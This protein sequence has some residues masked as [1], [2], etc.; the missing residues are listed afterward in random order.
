M[1][2]LVHF[3]SRWNKWKWE[4]TSSKHSRN[5]LRVLTRIEL[6]EYIV[7]GAR[8]VKDCIQVH[9]IEEEHDKLKF[10]GRQHAMAHFVLK[11]T[12]RMI[13]FWGIW[14][15]VGIL[16]LEWALRS[17]LPHNRAARHW[18]DPIQ[19]GETCIKISAPLV[20][21]QR[22]KV[23]T[24]FEQYLVSGFLLLTPGWDSSCITRWSA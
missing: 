20:G 1:F 4:L 16:V 7:G 9:D 13:F 21:R 11:E 10:V 3:H 18:Y 23:R 19:G 24:S 5:R 14:C 22:T 17:T 2:E 6:C 8:A 15:Q 12:T